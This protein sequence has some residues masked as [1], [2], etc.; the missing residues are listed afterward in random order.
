M[1]QT[2]KNSVRHMF[3]RFASNSDVLDAGGTSHLC[4]FRT[5]S[6]EFHKRYR[7]ELMTLA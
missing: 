2:E 6:P 1:A 7:G 5:G 3:F 4:Q